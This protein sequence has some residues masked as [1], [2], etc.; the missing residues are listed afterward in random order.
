MSV[1]EFA[2]VSWFSTVPKSMRA[3]H[4]DWHYLTDDQFYLD[5]HLDPYY[6]EAWDYYRQL[7]E[8]SIDLFGTD[9]VLGGY[10]ILGEVNFGRHLYDVSRMKQYVHLMSERMM[11]E[12][13]P[14][15]L[16]ILE[17]WDFG[18]REMTGWTDDKV[19]E[20][21]RLLGKDHFLA[22][23]LW[24]DDNARESYRDWN[25][26]ED[27]DWGIGVLQAFAGR[28][29]P[30]GDR[31]FILERTQSVLERPEG[32]RC[33]SFAYLP[34]LM[35]HDTL[36]A[37]L[38][39]K[40][41]WK[42]EGLTLEGFMRDYAL[43]RYGRQALEGMYEST[44]AV[45]E[46]V[47]V[48]QWRADRPVQ[49]DYYDHLFEGDLFGEDQEAKVGQ[50][51]EKVA[52]S[53]PPMVA[54]LGQAL[55]MCGQVADRGM[56]ETDLVDIARTLL[57]DLIGAQLG[58]GYLAYLAATRRFRMGEEATAERQRFEQ[59][60]HAVE[61]LLAALENLLSTREDFSLARAVEEVLQSPKVNSYADTTLRARQENPY[62]RS[63][64]YE[65]VHRVYRPDVASYLGLL[66]RHLE[67]RD[68]EPVSAEDEGFC[69]ELNAH[70]HRFYEQPLA[71]P[72]TYSG[73]TFAAV[74]EAY[75]LTKR[76][77]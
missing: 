33:I 17:T 5:T 53:A 58:G 19:R 11:Q 43:R 8:K 13:D 26:F 24:A 7:T 38:M 22:W 57:A 20:L 68:P 9:H 1:N 36:Y 39:G 59:A 16:W 29:E 69:R 56:Y 21:F 77:T 23:D 51:L 3:A 35:H 70:H 25:Y 34:E 15:A 54:G 73:T 6:P 49:R 28:D 12:I 72:R 37:Q 75:Q 71:V 60:A 62:C 61:E 67:A 50:A 76:L 27:H 41:A 47:S 66:R 30:V 44:A 14:G 42:P 64:V 40:L 18:V 74:E 55:A 46:G 10:C 4:P 31:R 48:Y 2:G 45:T 52:T 63:H 32:Q 65:L